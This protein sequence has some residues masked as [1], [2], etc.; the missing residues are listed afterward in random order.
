MFVVNL[1]GSAEILEH[2][3]LVLETINGD[4]KHTVRGLTNGFRL[5]LLPGGECEGDNVSQF[6]QFS[7]NSH[8]SH[9]FHD[10]ILLNLYWIS[11]CLAV[12]IR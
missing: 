2:F 11:F 6:K 10:K 7:V 9:N 1:F 4:E 5:N 8:V 3:L 12:I